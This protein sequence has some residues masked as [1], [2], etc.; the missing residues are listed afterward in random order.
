MAQ[1]DPDTFTSLMLWLRQRGKSALALPLRRKG[2]GSL[3][4]LLAASEQELRDAAVPE[5]LIDL[6]FG[7][8]AAPI[9]KAP[10]DLK[11]GMRVRLAGLVKS[12]DLNGTRGVV[13]GFDE[14][15]QRWIIDL[16]E[17]LGK[18]LFKSENLIVDDSRGADAA[19]ANAKGG[20]PAAQKSPAPAAQRSP[21]PA[22]QQSP[23][24]LAP[25]SPAPAAQ[26][27]SAPIAQK[28][29]APT[30]QK[31]REPTAPAVAVKPDTVMTSGPR[32]S[33]PSQ[34]PPAETSKAPEVETR[35]AADENGGTIAELQ[36]SAAASCGSR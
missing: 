12:H 3:T 10:A 31:T 4:A 36:D 2:F 16:G 13:A 18:K 19:P 20:K 26:Q 17:S 30:A 29:P 34:P 23:A 21:A 28:S 15:K 1:E 35:G 32:E 27:S 25:K 6:L 33:A 8:G 14:A 24:P 22:A 7:A 5:D 11:R 9:D